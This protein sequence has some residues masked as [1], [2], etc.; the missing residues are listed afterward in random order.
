MMRGR[1]FRLS[2]TDTVRDRRIGS[3]TCPVYPCRL[4]TTT[5]V[6]WRSTAPRCACAAHAGPGR[7][8]VGPDA[9]QH[10]YQRRDDAGSHPLAWRWRP[11]ASCPCTASPFH[12]G[13]G[14]GGGIARTYPDLTNG[15]VRV[16]LTS[17]SHLTFKKTGSG[18]SYH[19]TSVEASRAGRPETTTS[20]VHGANRTGG[21]MYCKGRSRVRSRDGHMASVPSYSYSVRA[22]CVPAPPHSTGRIVRATVSVAARE[23]ARDGPRM[24]RPAC[25]LRTSIGSGSC[26]T[27]TNAGRRAPHTYEKWYTT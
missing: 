23:F 17:Q 15:S 27:N 16:F 13:L 11:L 9:Q 18:M 7:V 26:V 14:V 1:W 5:L 12:H 20:G 6:V 2:R 21:S 19:C 8:V 25:V 3:R 22:P 4:R 10:E 24:R